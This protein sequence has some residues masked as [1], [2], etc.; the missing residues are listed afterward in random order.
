MRRS[1]SLATS[2]ALLAAACSPRSA[3]LADGTVVS[4]DSL[5][6][7]ARYRTLYAQAAAERGPKA[8]REAGLDDGEMAALQPLVAQ[9]ITAEVVLE[10]S[11]LA[12]A[13][14]PASAEREAQLREIADLRRE[15]PHRL[16]QARA[17]Y[18][19]AAVEVVLRNKEPL[20]AAERAVVR[21]LRVE[22][23]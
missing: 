11:L 23:R 20:A 6:R 10:E 19:G 9:I 16:E 14:G 12:T 4:D 1:L 5:A 7:Y 22:P 2:A 13:S 21:A 8:V 15:L 3:T 17:R 18:G